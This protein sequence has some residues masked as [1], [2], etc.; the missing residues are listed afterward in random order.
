MASYR[1]ELLNRLVAMEGEALDAWV[2]ANLSGKTGVD[3]K[4]FLFYQQ[5]DFP[6][7]VHRIGPSSPDDLSEDN[8]LRIY[9]VFI[10]VVVAHFTENYDGANEEMVD[11]IIPLLEQYFFEHPMLTTDS[12]APYTVE[13]TWIFPEGMTVGDTTGVIAFELGGIDATQIGEELSLE[14]PI[15]RFIDP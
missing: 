2:V 10:R 1:N 6:Y 4:P 12:T 7:I 3:A 5:E 9:D 13:P 11:E 8:S 14:V 15:F